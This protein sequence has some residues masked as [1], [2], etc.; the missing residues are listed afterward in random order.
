M[1]SETKSLLVLLIAFA[2]CSP[3]FSQAAA[4]STQAEEVAET[5]PSQSPICDIKATVSAVQKSEISNYYNITL[6]INDISTYKAEI[7]S[8]CNNNY[9][10]QIQKSGQILSASEYELNPIQE[11][12]AIKAMVVFDSDMS[13]AGYFLHD[14]QI[15]SKKKI[16]EQAPVSQ[17]EDTTTEDY[18]EETYLA[19]T[20][21]AIAGLII[22]AS[23]SKKKNI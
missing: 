9:A 20:I 17:F 12:D 3:Q 10:S 18:G 4:L 7:A 21:L 2:L 19:F 16:A 11:G 1:K 6:E 14:V 13:V 5:P 23:V 15:T 8:A 22:V